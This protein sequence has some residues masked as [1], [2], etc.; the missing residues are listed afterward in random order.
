MTFMSHIAP[1]TVAEWQQQQQQQQQNQQQDRF[2]PGTYHYFTNCFNL[3]THN[4]FASFC[5]L[6]L[7]ITYSTFSICFKYL[8]FITKLKSK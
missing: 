8:R 3:L 2:E 1:A 5:L 7:A 6:N 4:F